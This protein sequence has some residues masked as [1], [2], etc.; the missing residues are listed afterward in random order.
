MTREVATLKEQRPTA[1]RRA[2]INMALAARAEKGRNSDV[3]RDM[4]P[5]LALRR[6]GRSVDAFSVSIQA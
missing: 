5:F 2:K 1:T 4:V 3:F 6:S